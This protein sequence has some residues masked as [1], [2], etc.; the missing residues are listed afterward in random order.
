MSGHR[1]RFAILAG[2]LLLVWAGLI[3]LGGVA[4]LL[5]LHYLTPSIPA[6]PYH[7]L[8]ATLVVFAAWPL[9]TLA[10]RYSVRLRLWDLLGLWP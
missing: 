10:L 2:M 7:D 4:S 1:C 6:G 8:Y 9:F 5:L 3:L